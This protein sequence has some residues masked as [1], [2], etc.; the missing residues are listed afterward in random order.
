[1]RASVSPLGEVMSETKRRKDLNP[2]GTKPVVSF[3]RPPSQTV[4]QSTSNTPEIG[5]V[6]AGSF[7]WLHQ[8]WRKIRAISRERFCPYDGWLDRIADGRDAS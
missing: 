8:D 6:L 1:M 3:N 5:G 2:A 7:F 4:P